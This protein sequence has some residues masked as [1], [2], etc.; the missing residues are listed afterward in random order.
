MARRRAHPTLCVFMNGRLVGLF[1]K[2]PSGAVAFRYDDSWLAWEGALP[3]SLSLPL[4]EDAYTGASV[5]A[6]FENLL[7]D[8]EDIRRRMAAQ[9]GAQ[10]TDAHGLLAV[11]G[12]ECI[13]ALQFLPEDV[14]PNAPGAVE[15]EPLDEAEI[16]DMLRNLA[17]AP[18]GLRRDDA[19]RISLAGAQEKTALL[20]L[21]GE[22]RKPIGTTAT[23]HILK[24]AIGRRG[25]VDLSESVENEFFCMRLLARLGLPAARCEMARFEEVPTLVVERFDRRWTSD[26]RLL[27][28]P[29][30]DLCQALG[31]P[32]RDRYEA[33]GGPGAVEILRLLAA[34]DEP[35]QDRMRFLRANFI[36][37]LLGATDGHAKNFSIHLFPEGRFVM[38][39]LY[40]VM[41]V[42]PN[43]DRHEITRR[44]MRMAM[45]FGD[46]RRYHVHRLA[47]RH[48]V[49]TARAAGFAAEAVAGA[50]DD[51]A[52]AARDALEATREAL[53]DGF[54]LHV[55]DAIARGVAARLDRW[56]QARV[57]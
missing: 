25:A 51:L 8:S 10:S 7:P 32:P 42:Q 37:W 54:P 18:L 33:D 5:I 3:V 40:D 21:N 2:A 29:Q 36:Y 15:G 45:A 4:R 20:N 41:S 44:E 26:G 35:E 24:P 46:N 49:Q 39:P 31:R 23:T 30:E 28:L 53:P 52:W 19:F 22:W 11:A 6:V 50:L 43:L 38:T 47:P 9:I 16:A 17:Q 14:V 57:A 27:R 13:G 48:F 1:D 34:S 12:R 56:R 55:A